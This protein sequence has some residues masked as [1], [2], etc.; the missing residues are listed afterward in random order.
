MTYELACDVPL[1]ENDVAVCMTHGLFGSH[2]GVAFRN[3][4]GQAKLVHLA[5]HLTM[6]VEDYPA[7][8]WIAKVVQFHEDETLNLLPFLRVITERLK[9]KGSGEVEYGLNFAFGRGA[10]DANGDYHAERGKSGYTCSTIVVD[11]FY[12]YGFDL[13]KADEWEANDANKAWGDAV[14]CMLKA[15]GKA[16]EA[17]IEAV[18][19]S[20]VG[21]RITPEEVVA[22]S[23]HPRSDRPVGCAA[24][25]A[26]AKTVV[27]QMFAKCGPPPGIAF[28]HPMAPC[29]EIYAKTGKP[30]APILHPPPTLLASPIQPVQTVVR[31]FK[32]GRNDPCPCASGKKFKQCCG[33]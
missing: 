13:L 28:N 3:Q 25:Q 19:A 5:N 22:A 20:N 14:V 24:A 18:R 7:E 4:E 8:N 9:F 16:S 12:E 10:F 2:L 32:V 31:A 30:C 23:A 27:N 26:G 1:A 15:G 11:F 6:R 17:H 21:K 33:R 29:V